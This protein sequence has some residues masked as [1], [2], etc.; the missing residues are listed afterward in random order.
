MKTHEEVMDEIKNVVSKTFTLIS[1]DK[2]YIKEKFDRIQNT[3]TNDPYGGMSIFNMLHPNV[4]ADLLQK[5]LSI[6]AQ[7]YIVETEWWQYVDWRQ[8]GYW[9][10]SPQR[11]DKID[12]YIKLKNYMNKL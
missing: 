9:Q 5:V 12:N 8:N 7:A 10:V 4:R 3:N 11:K 1:H 2:D 6:D